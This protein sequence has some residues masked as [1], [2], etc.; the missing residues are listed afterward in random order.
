M[1]TGSNDAN[2]FYAGTSNNDVLRGGIGPD[3]YVFGRAIGHDIVDDQELANGPQ[4]PDTPRLAQFRPEDIFASRDGIDLILTINAT[5]ETITVVGQFTGRQLGLFGGNLL[6][7][8]GVGEII[9]ADGTVWDALE[10]AKAVRHPEATSDTLQ[11]TRAIDYLD[12]G[13]GDDILIGGNE[14]DHYFFDTGYGHDRI[15]NDQTD[16]LIDTPDFV[17]FG[18]GIAQD[19]LILTRIGDSNDLHI[20]FAGSPGDELT[21]TDQFYLSG[22]NENDTYIFGR[23]YGS[24]IIED[25]LTMILSGNDDTVLFNADVVPEDLEFHRS[26]DSSDL[27]ITIDGTDDVLTVRGQFRSIMV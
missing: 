24:D 16:I 2:I 4:T 26:G 27:Q 18:A 8:R 21:I 22:G 17:T 15:L 3:T 10:I 6:P 25:R 1:L 23:G 13:A 14:G 19:D 9:F 20:S 7:D 5:G 12:G 11:G